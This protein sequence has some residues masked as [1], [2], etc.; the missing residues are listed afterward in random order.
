MPK[1]C[2]PS[3]NNVGSLQVLLENQLGNSLEVGSP[4]SVHPAVLIPVSY[5]FVAHHGDLGGLNG[6]FEAM[7]K[8]LDKDE[9]GLL[10]ENDFQ[11]AAMKTV[12]YLG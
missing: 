6:L 5:F 2:I 9:K 11:A 4:S 8:H 12:R 3:L 1:L 10:T 7:F